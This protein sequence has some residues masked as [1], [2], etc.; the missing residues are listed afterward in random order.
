MRRFALLSC[1]LE[2][3]AGGRLLPESCPRGCPDGKHYQPHA[4]QKCQP[5][6]RGDV[7]CGCHLYELHNQCCEAARLELI[8]CLECCCSLTRAASSVTTVQTCVRAAN[9]WAMRTIAARETSAAICPEPPS[10]RPSAAI[11]RQRT[12]ILKMRRASR[13]GRRSR[14]AARRASERRGAGKRA[15]VVTRAT[16]SGAVLTNASAMPRL[17]H[18]RHHHRRRRLALPSC[19]AARSR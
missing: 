12:A 15:A 14:R 6:K 19:S 7:T 17:H 1:A 3:A 8:C 2:L 13:P 9:G 18:R 16:R 10:R 11:E 4:F 5:D